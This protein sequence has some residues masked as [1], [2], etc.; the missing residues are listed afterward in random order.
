MNVIFDSELIEQVVT[1]TPLADTKEFYVAKDDNGLPLLFSIG[2]DGHIYLTHADNLGRNQLS[3]LNARF[4]VVL[5]QKAEALAIYQSPDGSITV[6]FAHRIPGS[7][8]IVKITKPMS[9]G[10]FVSDKDDL[11]EYLL[12]GQ[13]FDCQV[14]GLLVGTGFKQG[15]T[16]VVAKIRNLGGTQDDIRRL[17]TTESSWSIK[18]DLDMPCNPSDIVDLSPANLPIGFGLFVLYKEGNNSLRLAFTGLKG[19]TGFY[20]S[21]KTSLPVPAGATSLATLLNLKGRSDLLI[22]AES[23]IYRL[24]ARQ[25]STSS[26]KLPDQCQLAAAD[27]LSDLKQIYATQAQNL[28]SIWSVNGQGDIVYNQFTAKAVATS[29]DTSLEPLNPA[30]PVMNGTVKFAPFLGEDGQS[31]R[32]FVLGNSDKAK[33]RILFQAGDSKIWTSTDFSIPV[34]KTAREVFTY[35][36]HIRIQNNTNN[37]RMFTGNVNISSSSVCVAT[38]N[39][40]VLQLSRNPI[41]VKPDD[42]CVITI[43]QEID[44]LSVPSIRLDGIPDC[45]TVYID[46]SSKVMDFFKEI[47]DEDKLREARLPNGDLLQAAKA[48]SSLAQHANKINGQSQFSSP[49]IEVHASTE[50]EVGAEPSAE[51]EKGPE[52]LNL[53]SIDENITQASW[54][55]FDWFTRAIDAIVDF[56]IQGWHFVVQ[57][58]K[59]VWKFLV[60]TFEHVMK[61]IKKV[62]EWIG[63]GLKKLWEGLKWLFNWQDIKDT[64]NIIRGYVNGFFDITVAGVQVMGDKVDLILAQMER[65]VQ[66]KYDPDAIPDGCDKAVGEDDSHPPGE[67]DKKVQKA[68]DSPGGNYANY[69]T[70]HNPE[71]RQSIT[72]ANSS[73]T[74]DDPLTIF[75]SALKA[76]LKEFGDAGKDIGKTFVEL[77]NPN[78]KA[79]VAEMVS[80]LGGRLLLKLVK[81]IRILIK[82]MF[83]LGASLVYSIKKLLNAELEIPVIS[84]LWSKISDNPLSVLDAFCLLLAAAY[85]KAPK[86]HKDFKNI[87]DS[88]RSLYAL[89]SL[90]RNNAGGKENKES[91]FKSARMM[92]SRAI[93]PVGS[94]SGITNNVVLASSSLPEVEDALESKQLTLQSSP[95]II[96]SRTVNTVSPARNADT[97]DDSGWI[98]KIKNHPL[99]QAVLKWVKAHSAIIGVAF[100]FYNAWK[101]LKEGFDWL[102]DFDDFDLD[103]D[104]VDLEIW[105]PGPATKK[106]G[107]QWKKWDVMGFLAGWAMT[108]PTNTNMES[109]GIR[110]IH[111]GCSLMAV[112]KTA[113]NRQISATIT[114][115]QTSIDMAIYTVCW[116]LDHLK[117]EWKRKDGDREDWMVILNVYL[118][119]AH[120]L[121]SAAAMINKGANPYVN[122]ACTGCGLAATV[123]G[124]ILIS[125]QAETGVAKFIIM[126]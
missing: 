35:T 94:T 5:G 122:I 77:F 67:D 51:N 120:D 3:D 59:R 1:S 84:W 39:G 103:L 50:E 33:M 25:C 64:Q 78:R 89:I 81:S 36:T 91:L 61:A 72:S 105:P 57:V 97:A 14:H 113:V 58:G 107:F 66:E 90:P 28:I 86:E 73:L 125:R 7:A 110:L 47:Q 104:E 19:E 9:P 13:E 4:K 95:A 88:T 46:P 60:N 79:T 27:I 63:T 80:K 117:P 108:F 100:G 85:G 68:V 45:D 23:G 124:G 116:P 74:P 41:P 16:L 15:T 21:L 31:Q 10:I 69:H 102:L 121:L 99:T 20:T 119:R 126:S 54:A 2:T 109:W 112:F 29:P 70:K 123:F 22:A 40:K 26:S 17:E 106:A 52:A 34:I 118:T 93:H 49:E 53:S 87:E 44:D 98:D 32:L 76:I 12:Q 96:S 115:I 114:I 75:W 42:Q 65:T 24:T 92:N 18:T 111:W 38:I 82:K 83:E 101:L 56:S 48:L 11:T 8:S 55:S 6:A 62:C 71:V 43:I 37:R 30:T